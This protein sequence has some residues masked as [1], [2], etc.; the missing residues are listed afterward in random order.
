M[1]DTYLIVPINVAVLAVGFPDTQNSAENLAPLADFSRLPWVANSQ[2]HNPGPYTSAAALENAVPFEGQIPLQQGIHV[3]WALPDGL[4][5]G[6][7]E[8]AGFSFPSAPNRWLVTRIV[9][10]SPSGAAA[11]TTLKS[12]VVESDR[13]SDTPTAPTGLN[14]PNMA[15]QLQPT[16]GQNF[17]Y[18]GQAFDLATWSEVGN[19]VSRL[20][21][22]TV[23]GYGQ[24]TF[25]AFYPNCSTVFGYYDTLSDLTDYDPSCSTISYHVSGWY[26]NAA[27]DPLAKPN[28]TPATYSWS[29]PGETAP[30]STICAGIMDAVPWN[31][32]TAYLDETTGAMTV[33]IGASTREAV[34][35]LMANIL[36]KGNPGQYDTAEQVLNA[37]QFGLLSGS[38]NQVDSLAAF[39]EDVHAAGFA[40][41]SAGPMW[42]V[43][44]AS[45]VSGD[46]SDGEEVTKASSVS[47][48]SSSGGEITLPDALAEQLNQLNVTQL[49]LND[50]TFQLQSLQ[51]QLFTDWYKYQMI[52]H[53][54]SLVPATLQGKSYNVQ[55][56]LTGEVAAIGTAQTQITNLQTQVGTLSATLSAALPTTLTLS[57]NIGAPRYYQPADPVFIL[58]GPDV[59]PTDRYGFDTA[60]SA[61][62]TLACRTDGDVVT[63]V[64]LAAGLVSGSAST[65]LAASAL[66]QLAA[67]PSC[68][69]AAL[70]QALVAEAFF[71]SVGL[72]PS[73]AVAVAAQGGATN[74]ATLNLAGTITAL[75]AAGTAF[76]AGA[77]PV[78]VS[79]AGTAPAARYYEAWNGTPWLPILMQY[80][81]QFAPVQ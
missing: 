76:L 22:F 37:L 45:S 36:Q 52:E 21:P 41:L 73:V 18:L 43:T 26:S 2:V 69:P 17:T 77:T 44:T 16:G 9:L 25:A 68:A 30:T 62:G 78:N 34:S 29:V 23:L 65:T 46:S 64:T 56:F 10:S 60:D 72:Q 4:T 61:D 38:S 31:P 80:S 3:H 49:Q 35:T 74:P 63:S 66:P 51:F 28:A 27:D 15:L 39:E 47:G 53:A 11:V 42:T 32:A 58:S 67:Q 57:N 6:N 50:A 59:T 5:A 55:Q 1:T 20:T 13:Q 75:G 14:Q 81:V 79:F 19:T 8:A 54:S 7:A 48:D 33:A 12:W 71:I 24:L 40:T 70:L